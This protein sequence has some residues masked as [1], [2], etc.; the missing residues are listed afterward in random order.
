ME[1]QFNTSS[2]EQTEKVGEAICKYFR[3]NGK[4]EALIAMR[5][6]MGVGKTAFVR[7]FCRPLGI[8]S[9]KSPTYTVVNAYAGDG[10]RIYHFD[11]YRIEGEE[12][13]YSIGFEEYLCEKDAYSLIEW[14]ERVEEL[15]P[16]ER[17]TVSIERTD[18]G[19]G[20]KITFTLPLGEKEGKN[21]AL[22]L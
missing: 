17:Y 16:R 4:S 5:G 9:V 1:Y 15:L 8:R 20:R 22:S 13:L 3:D 12:D 6:E 14:S 19:C 21:E 7:G 2:P 18:D 11:T 10:C